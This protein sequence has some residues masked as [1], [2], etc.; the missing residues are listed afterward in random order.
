MMAIPD[1]ASAAVLV[2]GD[3][4]LDR[5]WT[6]ATARIS[7]EA[8]VPVVQV[9]Q[10]ENRVGGA[11]NVAVNLASLG[12]RTRL[13]GLAGDDDDAR[14][15][16]AMLA[17]HSIQ[18]DLLRV[19]GSRTISKLRVLSRH[20]Q[21]IRL[22]FEDHFPAYSGL[23]FLTAFQRGVTEAKVVILSDYAK[24]ALRG[25]EHLISHARARGLPVIVDPK[26]KDFAP[27]RGA[28]LLTPNLLEFEAVAGA[29]SSQAEL[30]ARG[31]RLRQELDLQ[32]LLI[33]RGEHG[34]TLLCE[35]RPPLHLPAE[36]R[37][38]FDV[39]GAGDTVAALL[40]AGLAAGM[41]LADAV[42]LANLAAGI[43]V[44]KLGTAAIR[45]EE[46]QAALANKRE[47]AVDGQ[48]E[49]ICT[50]E[51]L[52]ALRERARSQGQRVVMTNGCFDILH[53][54]H[55]DYLEQAR[56]LGDRLIVAVNTDESVGRLKG[57]ADGVP[58][59][60]NPLAHRLRMLSALACVDWVVPFAEDT[61]ERLISRV[62]PDVLVKGGDYRPEDIAGG[63]S[64]I[65]AGGAVRVLGFL[66]GH[67]TSQL[68][69][70]IREANNA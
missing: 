7:P 31:E 29:C 54:G 50:E 12:V 47:P 48:P 18:P 42:V 60:V 56:A 68:I 67:S 57:E 44:G 33:T 24:G 65:Q 19:P 3:V 14:E 25:V 55:V 63:A 41:E 59:P 16:H 5:Y 2:A 35:K 61:P 6:G 53:P 46:L 45:R 37:E 49:G 4:M 26:G 27:Y 38:V 66:E 39:T 70:K 9:R 11:G 13:L 52:L 34:M 40:G 17:Q 28:T 30:E 43:V 36:A 58:R 8:P 62:L 10:Q 22:D 32:A 1:F 20:Q 15:L 23:D 64:V 69:N 21:L 51:R